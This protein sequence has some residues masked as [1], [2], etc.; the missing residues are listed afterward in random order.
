MAGDTGFNKFPGTTGGAQEN[1]GGGIIDFDMVIARLD[2]DL[3]ILQAATY[4]GGSGR[5]RANAIA[6]DSAGRIYVAGYT[7]SDDFPVTNGGAQ[8]NSAGEGDMAIARLDA[9]LSAVQAATYLGGNGGD[10]AFAIA[11]DSSG[12]I[13]CGGIY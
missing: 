13:S 7:S 10:Y 12:R 3:S 4:L 6:I 8:Q 5:E 2:A 1:S 9:D 11:I